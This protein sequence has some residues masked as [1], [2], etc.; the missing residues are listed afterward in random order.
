[1]TAVDILD[2]L[3]RRLQ[4][5]TRQMVKLWSP[6]SNTYR[7]SNNAA[8]QRRTNNF[9]TF[10]LVIIISL[11]PSTRCALSSHVPSI[12]FAEHCYKREVSAQISELFK[13]APDLR[14]DFR[15]FMPN[16]SHQ[17]VDDL[18]NPYLPLSLQLRASGTPF[19]DT[20]NVRRKADVTHSPTGGSAGLALPLKRKRKLPDREIE[21]ERDN[22]AIATSSKLA[23][24]NKVGSVSFCH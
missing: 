4:V 21:Q 12:S 24:G 22:N 1:M 16:R 13:D 9:W 7:K 11:T 17:L 2:H 20:K 23:S 8:I 15:V 14:S 6:P 5:S 19:N 18:G 10:W 3:D